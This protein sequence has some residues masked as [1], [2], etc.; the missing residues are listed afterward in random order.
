MSSSVSSQLDLEL[1]MKHE[2]SSKIIL[3][4]EIS[5]RT[6]PTENYLQRKKL[7]KHVT[8]IFFSGHLNT[9]IRTLDRETKEY[10]QRA[11]Q[12]RVMHR[13]RNVSPRFSR[14]RRLALL[15]FIFDQCRMILGTSAM[16]SWSQK[17]MGLEQT[18][19]I[20]IFCSNNTEMHVGLVTSRR[21]LK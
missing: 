11:Y 10:T 12:R 9:S 7:A 5:V 14:V 16:D 6:V 13:V 15:P 20:W 3:T 1:A 18:R 8:C 2:I 19:E 17:W 21:V 4:T